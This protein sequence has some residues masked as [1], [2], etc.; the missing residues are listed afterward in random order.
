MKSLLFL[1]G[2]LSL[3]LL[4][5][6]A[7]EAKVLRLGHFPNI[8]HAQAVYAHA[9]GDFEKAIGAPIQ[10]STFNAGPSAIEALFTGAIDATF[11]GPNPAI[12]GY[13]KTDGEGL[14]IVAGAASGGAALVVR[15]DA[16]I[17]N[18]KDFGDKSIAT[19]QLG[20]TQDVAAR[21]WFQDKGYKLKEKGGN[22]T[23]IPIANADQFTLFQKKEIAGAWTVEPWVSR[24]EQ[25]A[26]GKVFLEEKDLWPNGKY[27]TTHL[28]VSA[29]FLKKKPELIQKLIRAHIEVTQRINADKKAAAVIL[30]KEIKALTGK[31]LPDS[32]IASSLQRVEL[33]WDPISTSLKKSAEDAHKAGF[34]REN[35][36]LSHI[37]D[38]SLL[39]NV[40]KE[41]GLPS[42]Q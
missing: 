24:L 13:I 37:Y 19:P 28:I 42:V 32:V 10:W 41:K 4:T 1:F 25:E 14:R 2:L 31:A 5:A 29:A 22:L 3:F 17:A 16:G 26:Q 23:I 18:D 39:N 7:E 35:P 27:V 20:G 33:T 30:N 38:L 8:T 6:H 21:N 11:I 36:D 15:S 34:L 40:L 9:T 12:N